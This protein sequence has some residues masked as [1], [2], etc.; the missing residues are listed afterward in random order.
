[1]I[2]KLPPV[3]FK[4]LQIS[5]QIM[6]YFLS[7]LFWPLLKVHFAGHAH[8]KLGC[9]NVVTAWECGSPVTNYPRASPRIS[10]LDMA[11]PSIF[12]N[13]YVDI[14]NESIY[15]RIKVLIK[16]VCK[17]PFTFYLYSL[18]QFFKFRTKIPLRPRK[19]ATAQTPTPSNGH[20]PFCVTKV[21]MDV[22][23]N[24]VFKTS[25]TSKFHF[26]FIQKLIFNVY[27]SL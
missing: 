1:M 8:L 20:W 13:N 2:A 14:R 27:H 9:R 6:H 24:F 15:K 19:T 23:P 17:L 5:L 16:F 4:I 12:Y 22:V 26:V 10:L 25:C 18:I 7:R 3:G 21:G 11:R